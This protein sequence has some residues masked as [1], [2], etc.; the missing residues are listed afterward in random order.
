M[1]NDSP[2]TPNLW[3]LLHDARQL[4]EVM[5]RKSLGHRETEGT[6]AFATYFLDG[7]IKQF[8]PDIRSVIRGGDGERDGGYF[9]DQGRGFG[10]YWLEIDDNGQRFVADIT[11]DQFG[12]EPVRLLPLSV[13]SRTYV[14]GDDELVQEQMEVF[15]AWLTEPEQSGTEG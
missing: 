13:T 4:H 15:G 1:A 3:T 5:L 12:A 11:A 8:R 9:D 10:H 7:L 6:C 14:P 2:T